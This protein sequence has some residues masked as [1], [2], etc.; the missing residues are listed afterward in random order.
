MR[1]RVSARSY[2][3]AHDYGGRLMNRRALNFLILCAAIAAVGGGLPFAFG[4]DPAYASTVRVLNGL[5]VL[6]FLGALL[7]LFNIVGVTGSTGEAVTEPTGPAPRI[8]DKD[9]LG[10]ESTPL[11]QRIEA[12]A[13]A[14][15]RFG[16]TLGLIHYNI[17]AYKHVAR[18]EGAAAA[19]AMIDA[20]V[21]ALRGRL[22]NTDRVERLGKGRIVV[23]IVL[24]PEKAALETIRNRL[25]ASLREMQAKYPGEAQAFDVGLSIYPMGGY[26]GEDLIA[27][28][29]RNSDAERATRL[30]SESRHRR[31]NAADEDPPV[32]VAARR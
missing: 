24:L 7:S 6:G 28:A 14:S 18:A 32:R 12:A 13:E 9:V 27:T 20:M 29:A 1:G 8:L 19:E 16:R 10:A 26:T 31:S 17:D 23:V 5:G 3:C 25:D 30:R 15:Q 22:R 2:A 21:G 11:E 4:A